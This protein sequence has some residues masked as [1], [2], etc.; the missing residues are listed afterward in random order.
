MK[1]EINH[2]IIIM[3]AVSG[4]E[5]LDFQGDSFFFTQRK[6]DWKCNETKGLELF[7]DSAARNTRMSVT[8]LSKDPVTGLHFETL[9]FFV[10]ISTYLSASFLLL[11]ESK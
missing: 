3:M 11:V 1:I 10:S 5:Y 7:G 4:A 2:K 6:N 9:T 8:Y